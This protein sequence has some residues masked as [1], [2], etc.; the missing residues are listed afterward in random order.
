MNAV[1]RRERTAIKERMNTKNEQQNVHAAVKANLR[2]HKALHHLVTVPSTTHM[3]K[4]SMRQKRKP[5]ETQNPKHKRPDVKD[6]G[7]KQKA[8]QRGQHH[9]QIGFHSNARWHRV[10]K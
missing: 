10:A 6:V 5:L 9:F 3:H 4:L 7:T 2:I 1:G 8:L